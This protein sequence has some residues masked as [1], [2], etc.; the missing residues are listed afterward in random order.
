ML[1]RSRG[2]SLIRGCNTVKSPDPV[3]GG[4][5]L[6]GTCDKSE[7]A[8][9]IGNLWTWRKRPVSKAIVL[10][11][12]MQPE[13]H[14]SSILDLLRSIGNCAETGDA[15]IRIYSKFRNSC[16]VSEA[17]ALNQRMQLMIMII[18]YTI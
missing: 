17:F 14:H 11:Q 5:G 18:I 8:T 2:T 9:R 13:Y 16:S 12:G 7:D 15:T 6:R 4:D 10:K 1:S 3:V